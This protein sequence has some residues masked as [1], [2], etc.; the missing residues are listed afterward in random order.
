MV[1]K[2]FDTKIN[3]I[4]KLKR[5]A[6]RQARRKLKTNSNERKIDQLIDD[7]L[8]ELFPER[9]DR[10]WIESTINK[11]LNFIRVD[12]SQYP[13]WNYDPKRLVS[14]ITAIFKKR[15]EK[16]N[17]WFRTRFNNITFHIVD[18]KQE[19]YHENVQ[20]FYGTPEL[21]HLYKEQAANKILIFFK[22]IWIWPTLI[23]VLATLLLAYFSIHHFYNASA[24]ELGKMSIINQ[25]INYVTGIFGS[26]IMTFLMTR[27]LNLRQEKLKRAPQIKM[28]SDKL[29]Q[30]QK[31]CYHLINDDDFW[32]NSEDYKYAK[33]ISD[34][35]SYWDARGIR[36][37]ESDVEFH[38]FQSLITT[39]K[40]DHSVIWLHLQLK[41]FANLH[42]LKNLN[43][44]YGKYPPVK[45]YSFQEIDDFMVFYG[46]NE[47]ESYL[48]K[49]EYNPTYNDSPYTQKI[50][51]AAKLFDKE[52][53][54][55]GKY[56]RELL[57]EIADEVENKVL[58]DLYHLS[59]LNNKKVPPSVRYYFYSVL[60]IITLTVIWPV[61]FNLFFSNKLY[62]N[63]GNILLL[64]VFVHI[65]LMLRVFLQSEAILKSPDDY[66]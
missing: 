42:P 41:M 37:G 38:Y 28:L 11:K 54:K 61:I 30:F 21:K 8:S 34:R 19:H 1:R 66:R 12:F 15:M 52:K 16:T 23:A 49:K 14:E 29:A 7:I 25:N 35:I 27:V 17:M 2:F 43:L 64:G 5:N 45:I 4:H 53:F 6:V 26:F 57:I 65:L 31:I 36:V 47:L 56:S 44:L 51:D 13:N 60:S 24:E 62:L 46:H 40:F 63:I 20:I 39:P 22:N 32:N 59:I 9:N 10:I 48:N 50:V 18:A 58:P 3:E 33:R 55:D